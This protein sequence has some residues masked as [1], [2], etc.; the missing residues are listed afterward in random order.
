MLIGSIANLL[1]IIISIITA[2]VVSS[3]ARCPYIITEGTF[4]MRV[5]PKRITRRGKRFTLRTFL[6]RRSVAK[7]LNAL[8]EKVDIIM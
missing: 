2:L 1:E 4:T 6:L 7:Y 5:L 8:S 3:W